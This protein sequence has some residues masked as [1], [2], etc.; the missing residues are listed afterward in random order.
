M[1]KSEGVDPNH[2]NHINDIRIQNF[3][4]KIDNLLKIRDIFNAFIEFDK[5]LAGCTFPSR[6]DSDTLFFNVVKDILNA[7]SF[8]LNLD[9][10]KSPDSDLS[11]SNVNIQKKKIPLNRSNFVSG[12]ERF[13]I[14]KDVA[15]NYVRLEEIKSNPSINVED[16]NVKNKDI[17]KFLETFKHAWI[18]FLEIY[19]SLDSLPSCSLDKSWITQLIEASKSEK[20]Q[21]AID[22]NLSKCK[23][24]KSL[25]KLSA[26]IREDLLDQQVISLRFMAFKAFK[27]VLS[28]GHSQL[29][30]T[31]K[32]LFEKKQE[33]NRRRAIEVLNGFCDPSFRPSLDQF[34]ANYQNKIKHVSKSYDSLKQSDR[35][36]PKLM[37]ALFNATLNVCLIYT[38][39][40]YETQPWFKGHV[41]VDQNLLNYLTEKNS[42]M[43]AKIKE[44]YLAYQN[45]CNW[46][47]KTKVEKLIKFT[48]LNNTRASDQNIIKQLDEISTSVLV[49]ESK[50]SIPQDFLIVSFLKACVENISVFGQL[51]S[52]L[53]DQERKRKHYVEAFKNYLIGFGYY[54]ELFDTA[55]VFLHMLPPEYRDN[56]N[57]IFKVILKSKL[58]FDELDF[59]E[60]NEKI[61][62]FIVEFYNEKS[63]QDVTGALNKALGI[64][65]PRR[66]ESKDFWKAVAQYRALPKTIKEAQKTLENDWPEISPSLIESALLKQIVGLYVRYLQAAE[67][68]LRSSVPHNSISVDFELID[69]ARIVNFSCLEIN[70]MLKS[71]NTDEG[72]QAL[73]KSERTVEAFGKEFNGTISE[74]AKQLTEK[75]KEALDKLCKDYEIDLGELSSRKA[76]CKIV[77]KHEVMIYS[78]QLDRASQGEELFSNL[79]TKHL[80]TKP[81]NFSKK[82]KEK[83]EEKVLPI[84][85]GIQVVINFLYAFLKFYNSPCFKEIK[86]VS[87][88]YGSFKLSTFATV[89]SDLKCEFEKFQS[90][91]AMEDHFDIIKKTHPF[92]ELLRDK[93]KEIESRLK[94]SGIN[95][96]LLLTSGKLSTFVEK[97]F[98]LAV[99]SPPKAIGELNILNKTEVSLLDLINDLLYLTSH[100]FEFSDDTV[101][102]MSKKRKLTT[103]NQLAPDVYNS[104]E[105][106]VYDLTIFGLYDWMMRSAQ[107]EYNQ[108]IRNFI[109]PI[110]GLNN[111]SNLK[112]NAL[113]NKI[114][115]LSSLLKDSE[116]FQILKTISSE[117]L[118]KNCL[119]GETIAQV[120]QDL[121]ARLKQEKLDRP[122]RLAKEKLNQLYRSVSGLVNQIPDKFDVE[123]IK[124]LDPIIKKL[125]VHIKQIHEQPRDFIDRSIKD[126]RQS[127]E[128]YLRSLNRLCDVLLKENIPD[129]HRSFLINIMNGLS[130]QDLSTLED[131][132][133]EEELTRIKKDKFRDAR[134]VIVKKFLDYLKKENASLQDALSIQADTGKLD[135]VSENQDLVSK[136]TD[137]AGRE[138]QKGIRE[139]K[140]NTN[141]K[142]REAPVPP[143]E[144]P[145]PS[146]NTINENGRNR[147]NQPSSQPYFFNVNKKNNK[148]KNKNAKVDENNNEGTLVKS[149]NQSEKQSKSSQLP[150]DTIG[151]IKSQKTSA[152]S[153]PLNRDYRR[154]INCKESYQIEKGDIHTLSKRVLKN[155]SG[156]VDE[157]NNKTNLQ[158]FPWVNRAIEEY[159]ERHSKSAPSPIHTLE[160]EETSAQSPLNRDD[161]VEE[162]DDRV[163]ELIKASYQI[164]KDDIQAL[165]E[166][167]LKELKEKLKKLKNLK[168][169]RTEEE[170]IQA[171]C[172]L[173]IVN[174]F[175]N[176]IGQET[177]DSGIKSEPKDSQRNVESYQ[178]ESYQNVISTLPGSEQFIFFLKQGDYK[179]ICDLAERLSKLTN[180]PDL[181]LDWERCR[182]IYSE[183][184]R[185]TYLL[186]NPSLLLNS[187]KSPEG[188]TFAHLYF[189]QCDLYQRI[190]QIC[191]EK[192]VRT[193]VNNRSNFFNG[194]IT[195]TPYTRH[196]FKT[197]LNP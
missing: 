83:E 72:I 162:L 11:N 189:K 10:S 24:L 176:K 95:F 33:I 153:R 106:D 166:C 137:N 160:C 92:L 53:F 111:F 27:M 9:Q 71:L 35:I 114:K 86:D 165:S 89:T 36:E 13:L 164:K 57:V 184:K 26:L 195:N 138:M 185:L 17:D 18:T 104:I 56:F 49:P 12:I 171:T 25:E 127:Y 87:D 46:L 179:R 67:K 132:A 22:E 124:K 123:A 37:Q 147:Y 47:G 131:V 134:K 64:N 19:Q 144:N 141:N 93:K 149:I 196:D 163:K 23:V 143:Q 98:P 156:E 158:L 76:A 73:Q 7:V 6:A 100:T 128:G 197:T 122:Y 103:V 8:L 148:N 66:V 96:L 43:R 5:A 155:G 188:Y 118:V 182:I 51:L 167:V 109:N 152:Q 178:V 145:Q 108:A 133:L 69:L 41:D 15:E 42:S 45:V 140:N 139:G 63:S 78:H 97:E 175:C 77:G 172:K 16:I 3:M 191:S 39:I 102:I 59:C 85:Y 4:L 135:K 32:L 48:D 180:P 60:I 80:K 20:L 54:Q 125:A 40:V 193:N 136:Q 150:I 1:A 151:T 121:L 68:A 81:N 130:D 31:T 94:E 117:V 75:S 74:V 186:L 30:E 190:W 99:F 183:I 34:I 120:L 79:N 174:K 192:I 142:K 181:G 170:K 14:Q 187:S 65:L 2:I 161:Q 61:N 50:S 159:N 116:L 105:S 113:D 88:P 194:N 173:S 115:E 107:K 84:V 177:K 129:E 21:Q 110:I 101:K 29:R 154:E 146:I 119:R 58:K 112:D 90:C 168:T 55:Y 126:L 62:N 38:G 157:K 82:E 169:H 70:G 91:M 52:R 28:H 44:F